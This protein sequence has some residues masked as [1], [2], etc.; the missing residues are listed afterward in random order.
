MR[1]RITGT[2][3]ASLAVVISIS[4]CGSDRDAPTRFDD[5]YPIYA[6]LLLRHVD[7]GGWVDYAGLKTD[8][9]MVRRASKNLRVLSRD[10]LSQFSPQQRMAY[11]IN[12][13]N[14]LLLEAVVPYY[15]VD[16]IQDILNVLDRPHYKV[17]EQTV[18]LN[19]IEKNILWREFADPRVCFALCRA[20]AGSPILRQEPYRAETLR[21]QLKE[22]AFRF[23][24]DSSRNAFDPEEQY[25]SI[26]RVFE[27]YKREI[28]KAYASRIPAD[29]PEEVRAVFNFI[30][31]VLPDSVGRFLREDG[32]TWSY[33]PYDWS[34]NDRSMAVPI[35]DR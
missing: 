23:L 14:L 21:T 17:A 27:W 30:A 20:S 7:D 31:E 33:L 1:R 4:S 34:L 35:S 5:R 2:L 15:P 3:L 9:A 32:V 11:W 19:D 10:S 24:T 16:S 13:Y 8:S 12:A 29:Q 22:A 18:S 25:T 26:S 6:E 28:N